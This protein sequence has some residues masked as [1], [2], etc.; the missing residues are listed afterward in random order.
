MPYL[1]SGMPLGV[2]IP[3][4]AMTTTLRLFLCKILLAMSS[5][6]LHDELFPAEVDCCFLTPTLWHSLKERNGKTHFSFNLVPKLEL[7]NIE[8]DVT[9]CNSIYVQVP[10]LALQD[11]TATV[12]YSLT[13]QAVFG[14]RLLFS[15]SNMTAWK[16]KTTC[17]R[18]ILALLPLSFTVTSQYTR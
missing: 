4:P 3:A 10:A 2:L 12:F 15:N 11:S 1:K 14:C 16:A 13:R 7:I 18:T 9:L 6:L 17:R 5:M 8:N